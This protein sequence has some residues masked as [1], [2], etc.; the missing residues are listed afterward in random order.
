MAIR[1][2][3]SGT[4]QGQLRVTVQGEIIEQQFGEREVWGHMKGKRPVC[5]ASLP[6]IVHRWVADMGPDVFL[7][8]SACL[9]LSVLL[10]GI[11]QVAFRTLDL[12]TSAVLEAVL[13]P[14]PAPSEV[15]LGA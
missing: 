13:D 11:S 8:T 5:K 10:G 15:R 4:I 3:P 14:P 1:S 12:Y 9:D 2:Q 7:I 6:C